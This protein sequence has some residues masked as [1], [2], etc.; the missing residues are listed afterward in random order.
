[1]SVPNG[2]DYSL[3]ICTYN[4]LPSILRR[5]LDA[6]AALDTGGMSTEVIL[7][8]NNSPLPVAQL[9]FVQ[10]YRLMMPHL[11][12]Y[13]EKKQG[14]KYG[15]MLAIQKAKGKHIVLVDTDN[16]LRADYLQQL[17]QLQ[18][19][20]PR[21][22]AW[23]PGNVFVEFTDGIKGH[24]KKY[25]RGAFQERHEET[26]RT[27]DK[28]EWQDCY[29]F[30]TG[31]CILTSMMREYLTG[32]KRGEYTLEGRKGH[33]LTSGEDTQMIMLC[34]AKG[35][36][37][38]VAPQLSLNHLIPAEKA[39]DAYLRRLAFGTALCYEPALLQVLP[40]RAS[41]VKAK[42]LPPAT[43]CRRSLKKVAK[44]LFTGKEQMYDAIHDIGLQAGVYAAMNQKVPKCVQLLIKNLRL[45]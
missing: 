22:G 43:Y 32:A 10:E 36:H 15:R 28:L 29:P 3:V 1:M 27:S 11:R 6:V 25:A 21:V 14:V 42:M 26:I 24:L 33:L 35:Y 44:A 39:N 16:E 37:A 40:A 20:Y 5:C 2:I 23:G 12:C 17:Q 19:Q 8:D 13:V 34:I 38:G 7:V 4:P 41:L 31:L 18:R 30:G 9:D 45:I